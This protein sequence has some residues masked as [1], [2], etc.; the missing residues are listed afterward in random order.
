MI[1]SILGS[2]AGNVN[3]KTNMFMTGLGLALPAM[4]IINI[5]I[6][7]YWIIRKKWWC[8]L[9]VIALFA[10]YNYIS[11]VVQ[12]S[13]GAE[14]EGKTLKIMTLNTRSFIDDNQDDSA[15]NIKSY[16]ED[17]NINIVCFQE[18]REHVSGRP[19]KISNFLKNMFP[20][21]AISG[22]MAIFSKYP[23]T[24]KDYLTFRESNNSA[25]WVD[26][27]TE[28]KQ[29]IR[30]INVHMQTTG[31]NSAL[32]HAS[33]MENNGI[34][35]DNSQ[36]AEI[37]AN[38][39]EYEYYRRAEQADIISD[40]IK[41]T[42]TPVILC[43]DFNDTPASY[44]YKRLKGGLNDG[45]KTAGKGYMYTYRGAKKLM[46]I[47]YILHSKSLKGVNYYSNSKNWSDHN[48]VVMELNI[49]SSSL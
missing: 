41:Q 11:A 26:I 38:R 21:Q 30:I 46:R 25:Q 8:M 24:K 27:E 15:D 7:I 45:F 12:F 33:K 10:N 48:P 17:E 14:S 22:S 37:V 4:L 13:G 36:R 28:Q 19:E 23:I 32:R 20:H 1:T 9:P 5:I 42:K 3:P 29:S 16:M 44:T 47:D 40:I 2:F 34:P 6:L 31:V 35:I 43:G 18:Y 39:M 49:P